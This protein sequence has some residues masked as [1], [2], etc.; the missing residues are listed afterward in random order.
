MQ[1]FRELL[2]CVDRRR[3]RG[4]LRRYVVGLFHRST[5]EWD[6]ASRLREL[7]VR[8]TKDDAEELIEIGVR[9]AVNDFFEG[10]PE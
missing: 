4:V 8:V 9:N 6:D 5:D 10:V 2:S 1:L 7:L 3:V